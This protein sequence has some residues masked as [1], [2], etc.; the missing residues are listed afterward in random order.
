MSPSSS[1]N[2]RQFLQTTAFALGAVAAGHAEPAPALPR[3]PIIGFSKPFSDFSP[4]DTADL[5][6]EI[7]WAG[8]E[9]PVR[10]KAT[11]IAP[12]RVEEDLPKMVEALRARGKEVTMVTTDILRADPLAEKILKTLAKLGIRKYRLGFAHYPPDRPIPDIVREFGAAL[13]DLS[14]LSREL[15]LQGGYQNHSGA[16][17]IGAPIWDLWLMM[18]EL[19][20]AA[21]GFCF[22]IGQAMIE[23]GL[24]WPVQ[25]R[26]TQKQ[27]VAVYLKDFYWEKDAAKGWQPRWCPLGEGRVPRQFFDDLKAS[28]FA[29][30]I[31][32][33]HEHLKTGLPRAELLAALK[34]DY[35]TLRS[36]LA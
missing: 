18:K 3:W 6:A 29:G 23:G 12:E 13:K 35:S 8:I 22:D 4:D 7:G 36:W 9:C 16:D 5:V 15:G 21:M 10:A 1:L 17:Y 27:W 31:S 30:P 14:A 33:H 19:D 26:L 34:Q 25:A 11:H 20:P 24:S 28:S 32:Q 2:R